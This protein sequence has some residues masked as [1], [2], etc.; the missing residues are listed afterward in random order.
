MNLKIITDIFICG[1]E[2]IIIYTFFKTVFKDYLFE[3]FTVK[4]F[5]TLYF[6]LSSINTILFIDNFLLLFSINVLMLF[7]LSFL[8]KKKISVKIFNVIL[9]S[10]IMVLSE[11]VTGLTL[12]F[13]TN[14]SVEKIGSN[15]ILFMQGV[16]ISKLVVFIFVKILQYF[17]LSKNNKLPRKLLFPLLAIPISTIFMIY[18]ISEFL[19]Q[20]S[21]R[22]PGILIISTIFLTIISNVLVFYLFDKQ[23]KLDEENRTSSLIKQQLEYQTKY[24][25][26]LAEK[27]KLSN[28]AIHDMK[29]KLF[30]I[31]IYFKNN[32][33]DIAEEK[34]NELCENVFNTLNIS[35]TGNDAVDALI[36]AKCQKM[37]NLNIEYNQNIFMPL[38]SQIDDID[39]CVIIGNA[40]DNAIEACKKIEENEKEIHLKIKQINKY[41]YLE[42]SNTVKKGVS[43]KNGAK[44]TKAQKHLHGF[45]LKSIRETVKKYNGNMDF[46]E[47]NNK[48]ILTISLQ[49]PI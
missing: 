49:N 6:V 8:Y 28:K 20:L 46:T 31:S 16:F 14:H 11:I 40:L 45:G 5:F 12:M 47:N 29:N 23:L 7:S 35:N 24:F 17:N 39:L 36:N 22:T 32:K 21:D 30:A 42:F 3:K 44:T 15:I 48:V 25:K 1:F 37:K 41:L 19:F 26:E 9:I 2:A 27:H 4:L 10:V 34:I 13:I 18:I 38:N 33:L 43:L